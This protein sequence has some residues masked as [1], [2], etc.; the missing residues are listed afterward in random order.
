MCVFYVNSH[1]ITVIRY[2]IFEQ[3]ED[4]RVPFI[5][6]EFFTSSFLEAAKCL[7]HKLEVGVHNTNIDPCRCKAKDL[8]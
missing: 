8:T 3:N 4:S 6:Q 5:E 7:E 1:L 2:V